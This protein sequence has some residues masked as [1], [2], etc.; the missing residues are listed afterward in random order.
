MNIIKVLAYSAKY[1]PKGKV[2]FVFQSDDEWY[3][4]RKLIL[5]EG[6]ATPLSSI[7]EIEMYLDLKLALIKEV[8]GSWDIKPLSQTEN[9]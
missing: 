5:E 3:W 9:E 2:L 7:Q 1:L 4:L 6:F 8:D